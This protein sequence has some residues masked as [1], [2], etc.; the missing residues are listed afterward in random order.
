[1]IQIL[2]EHTGAIYGLVSCVWLGN[3][4]PFPVT[5]Q[6]VCS[7]YVYLQSRQLV[8]NLILTDPNA[9]SVVVFKKSRKSALTNFKSMA[10]SPNATLG[11]SKGLSYSQRDLLPFPLLNGRPFTLPALSRCVPE[12]PLFWKMLGMSHGG[13]TVRNTYFRSLREL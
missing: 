6:D 2:S 4:V 8:L 12:T 9:C 11:A 13:F 1:M 10:R 7:I 3:N 5:T